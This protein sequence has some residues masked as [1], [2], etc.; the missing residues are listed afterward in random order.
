[1]KGKVLQQVPAHAETINNPRKQRKTTWLRRDSNPELPPTRR[2]RY[3]LRHGAE[4]LAE[5]VV[6]QYFHGLLGTNTS[7][8]GGFPLSVSHQ[9]K[10]LTVTRW[11]GERG[12]HHQPP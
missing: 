10:A 4:S 2:M 8:S 11:A 1:M 9:F 3:Q 7:T 6:V 12:L 5:P